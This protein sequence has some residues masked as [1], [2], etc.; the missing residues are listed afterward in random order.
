[1][2]GNG[3]TA[4][5]IIPNIAPEVKQLTQIVRAKHWIVP[6]LKSPFEGPVFRWLE[7][8]LPGF[9]AFERIAIVLL[10]E[11]HFLQTFKRDG[12]GARA[13]FAQASRDY[14]QRCAP[15]EY[16]DIILPKE[17]E[18]EVSCKRRIYDDGYIV[19]LGRPNVE[20]TKDQASKIVEDG[21]LLE[22]GRKLEADVIVLSTGF[23][24]DQFALQ[25]QITNRQGLRLEDYWKQEKGAPQAY[26]TEMC[27]G[28]PNMFII[29]GPNSVTGHFS[30]IWA[31]ERA[32]EMAMRVLRPLFLT[33]DQS[34]T[35]LQRSQGKSVRVRPEAEDQEQLYI[36][37]Q[38][39]GLMFTS[40]CGSW[41][42]DQ[43]T[44]RVTAVN[45][46]FQLTVAFRSKF[47]FFDDYEYK[48]MSQRAAWNAWPLV[49][50]I[51]SI[52]RLGATPNVSSGQTARTLW[53][54]LANLLVY[55]S[56]RFAVTLLKVFSW[57]I[58]GCFPYKRPEKFRIGSQSTQ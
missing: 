24:T 9:T 48:G 11:S 27:A 30:A 45:P 23:Q 20:L 51:G 14:V 52:L 13:R 46:S 12:K 6:Q 25:M 8:H 36:Q 22:S 2:P 40:G 5:Q 49:T 38:M 50:R 10:C 47:P 18:L 44:G 56:N 33:G 42:A 17:D 34:K 19:S 39:Q 3:C 53:T 54:W 57:L 32:V 26:R 15:K 43:K 35:Q 16:H 55:F 31:Q 37:H 28:F 21:V 1:L 58:D 7:S 4:S 41:Y 29:W